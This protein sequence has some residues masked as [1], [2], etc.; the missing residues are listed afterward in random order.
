MTI[1]PNNQKP[2]LGKILVWQANTAPLDPHSFWTPKEGKILD[3]SQDGRAYWVQN[4]EGNRCHWVD[5]ESNDKRL[6][7]LKDATKN[8]YIWLENQKNFWFIHVIDYQE[9]CCWYRPRLFSAWVALTAEQQQQ[10]IEEEVARS[11]PPSYVLVDRQT[12]EEKWRHD[13]RRKNYAIYH[14]CL[15][16]EPDPQA[17]QHPAPDA[18]LHAVAST[19]W[20]DLVADHNETLP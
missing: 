18:S 17:R 20:S 3:V 2:L 14:C 7:T 6:I 12:Y 4:S 5:R 11:F 8:T 9:G 10:V 1:L 15:S 13:L 19:E 16:I